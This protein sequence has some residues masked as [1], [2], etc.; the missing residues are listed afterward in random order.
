MFVSIR[1]VLHIKLKQALSTSSP[2]CENPS[3]RT[4]GH[5]WALKELAHG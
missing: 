5:I 1:D 2:R 4:P 3:L